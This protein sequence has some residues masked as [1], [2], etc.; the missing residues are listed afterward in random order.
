MQS[1]KKNPLDRLIDNFSSGGLK[2]RAWAVIVMGVAIVVGLVVGGY[3]FMTHDFTV[4]AGQPAVPF[5][6][7]LWMGK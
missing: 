2:K 3:F 6:K 5:W 1:R 7:L 4:E